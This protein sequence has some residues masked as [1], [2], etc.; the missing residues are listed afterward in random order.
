MWV[1]SYAMNGTFL[2]YSQLGTQLTICP[3]SQITVVSDFLK[4]GHNYVGTC[5]FDLNYI[6]NTTDTLFYELYIRDLN[7]N[8][9]D[10]PVRIL[11]YDTSTDPSQYSYVRRFFMYDNI[12]Y[13]NVNDQKYAYIRWAYSIQLKIELNTNANEQ[14][15]VPTLTIQYRE[16]SV[17]YLTS[18]NVLTQSTFQVIY[19]MNISSFL[20]VALIFLIILTIIAICIAIYR[21]YLWR[22]VN[23]PEPKELYKV[24]LIF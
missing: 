13:K 4:M 14:I 22:Q 18:N 7:G 8:L 16:R 15:Y 21:I 12:C 2:G 20:R 17:S 5:Q 3:L 23:P 1:A 10:V 11:N 6:L 9:Y 24:R 19:F